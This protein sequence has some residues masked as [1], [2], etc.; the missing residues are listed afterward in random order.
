MNDQQNPNRRAIIVMLMIPLSLV[1]LIIYAT[2]T[3]S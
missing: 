1:A 2:L 3:N